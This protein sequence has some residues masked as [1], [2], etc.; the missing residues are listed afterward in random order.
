VE[1]GKY[2]FTRVC[3]FLI[4]IALPTF[5]GFSNEFMSDYSYISNADVGYIDQLYQNYKKDPN[6][7]DLTWQKFFEGYDF[8]TKGENGNGH[9]VAVDESLSIKETQVR[10][11]IFTYRSF[12]HLT[13]KTN[14]VRPRRNHHV[15]FDH[16]SVGLTDADLDT[17]FDVGSEIGMG[18]ATLRKIIEKLKAV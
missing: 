4:L 12:G 10:N 3:N 6:S 8:S 5:E 11:L 17:E 2:S 16:K 15:N 9:S 13:S 7:V 18:R 1:K 14:P